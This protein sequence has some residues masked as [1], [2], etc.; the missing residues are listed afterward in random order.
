MSR[1]RHLY[2]TTTGYSE[3]ADISKFDEFTVYI[4]GDMTTEEFIEQSKD[5]FD[6]MR[7]EVRETYQAANLAKPN[8][9]YQFICA[10]DQFIDCEESLKGE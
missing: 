9:V 5:M 2:T 10:V 6:E 7:E 4:I 1:E 3:P 8:V